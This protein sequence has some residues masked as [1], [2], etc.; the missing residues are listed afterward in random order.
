MSYSQE[1]SESF[2]WVPRKNWKSVEMCIGWTELTQLHFISPGLTSARIRKQET[3]LWS[4]VSG[5]LWSDPHT[6]EEDTGQWWAQMG[7]LLLCPQNCPHKK[8][9]RASVYKA[10]WL[11][12][13]H[14]NLYV[15]L[16]TH[17]GTYIE[18]WGVHVR[19]NYWENSLNSYE[20]HE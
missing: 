9:K 10:R 20:T 16:Q 6:K 7:G 5:A 14:V 2:H 19:D 17:A 18:F 12:R 4:S 13:P 3:G 15:T 11:C 8:G 1:L